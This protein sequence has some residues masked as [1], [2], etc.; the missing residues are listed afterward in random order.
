[1]YV[2]AARWLVLHRGAHRVAVNLGG[3]P[4]ALPLGGPGREVVASFG[5]CALD[6][7][8]VRLGPDSVAVVRL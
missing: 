4:A 1:V 2:E 5:E 7:T 3:A 6:G 8:A